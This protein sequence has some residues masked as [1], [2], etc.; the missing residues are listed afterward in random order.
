MSDLFVDTGTSKPKGMEDAVVLA[1]ICVNSAVDPLRKDLGA[2]ERRESS[3]CLLSW[4]SQ[5]PQNF[6]RVPST[7][8]A[9]LICL[10]LFASVIF[11]HRE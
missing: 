9:A 1:L 8:L 2:C 6:S 11:V 4:S 10:Q 5:A 3:R 7:L